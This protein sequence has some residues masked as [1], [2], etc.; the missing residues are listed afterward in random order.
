MRK[1]QGGYYNI[2]DNK[3]LYAKKVNHFIYISTGAK[4]SQTL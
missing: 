4:I 2:A 3:C 1:P